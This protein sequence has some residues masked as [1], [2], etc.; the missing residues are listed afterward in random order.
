MFH[1]PAGP[2]WYAAL[3]A[4]DR[5][6]VAAHWRRLPEDCIRRRFLRR[7]EPEALAAQAAA[8]VAPGAHA[9]GWVLDGRLRGIAELHP[10]GPVGEVALTVEPEWRRRG[11]GRGLMRR[12]LRRAANRGVRTATVMSTRGNT[13]MIR[14][15]LWAGA[16]LDCDRGEVVGR[17]ALGPGTVASQAIEAAETGVATAASLVGQTGRMATAWIDA[18]P[19]G[20]REGDTCGPPPDGP[21]DRPA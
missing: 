7:M 1:L 19:S 10:A 11:V 17:I 6:E 18:G 8:T 16:E 2:S 14:L 20:R 21:R 15:A 4:V 13:A 9:I 12:I 3:D 5:A